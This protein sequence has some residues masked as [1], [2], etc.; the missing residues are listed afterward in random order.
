MTI[1]FDPKSTCPFCTTTKKW[2]TDS[3]IDHVHISL[4]HDKER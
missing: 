2:T 3:G 1:S 4:E